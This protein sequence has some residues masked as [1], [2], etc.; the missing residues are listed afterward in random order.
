MDTLPESTPEEETV[1]P[2]FLPKPSLIS[3]YKNIFFAICG[4]LLA[5]ILVFYIAVWRTPTD[6]PVDTIVSVNRGESLEEITQKFASLRL[7]RSPFAFRS[8]VILL[9]GEKKVTAGDYLMTNKESPLT[10]AWRIIEG[11]L[12][13]EPIKVTIP[14]GLNVSEISGILGKKLALFDAELFLREAKDKEGYLFPDTYF[15]PPTA[16]PVDVILKMQKNFDEKMRSVETDIEKFGK[17]FDEVL[18]MASILEGE[19]KDTESRKIVAGILWK[20]ISIG[21]PLQVDATFKYINGKDSSNLT[22]DD[23]KM[24]N[25][26]NT[27]TNRGLP[28]TPINNPGLDALLAAV[29][30]TKTEYLYF[31]TGN[32]GKMYYAK[33]FEQHKVNKQKYLR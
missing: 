28:P 25:A 9:G 33:T 5:L 27:Y 13:M 22:L 17:P 31:L 23:L 16:K 6:F 15:L 19:A 10:L 26:Y 30:P 8:L 32:D 2:L 29:T 14:E 11:R 1:E 4:S 12:G 18:I 21:M 20:R 3:R 24:D 7:I